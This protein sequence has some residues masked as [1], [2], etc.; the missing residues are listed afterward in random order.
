MQSFS[1]FSKSSCRSKPHLSDILQDSA[2]ITA[3]SAARVFVTKVVI[4]KWSVY[5]GL[6]K[7]HDY[8]F[9]TVLYSFLVSPKNQLLRAAVLRELSAIILWSLS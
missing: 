9:L 7:D 4:A 5:H 3:S 6:G 1:K 2:Y 8:D